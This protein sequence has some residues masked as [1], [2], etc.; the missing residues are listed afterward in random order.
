M[1][2][3]AR[4]VGS[5]LASWDHTFPLWNTAFPTPDSTQAVAAE[6]PHAFWRDG[7]WWLFWTAHNDSIWAESSFYGPVDTVAAGGRWTR[8]QKLGSLVPPE[9]TNWFD[10]WHASEYLRVDCG[11][12]S[13][14]YLGAFS[15]QRVGIEYTKMLPPPDTTMSFAMSC[16]TMTAAVANSGRVVKTPRLSLGGVNPARSQVRLRVDLPARMYVYVAVYDV[17]GRRVRTLLDGD[18]PAG[19]TRAVWDGRDRTGAAVGSGVYFARLTTAASRQVVR[20][21]LIR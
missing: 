5:D 6:S 1:I 13:P 4:A 19:A 7:R 2:G 12:Y 21:L 18:L 3:V 14:E 9:Q 20:V 17:Q 11:S 15:D 8:P 10:N 16:D